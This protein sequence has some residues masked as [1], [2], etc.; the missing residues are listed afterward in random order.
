MALAILESIDADDSTLRFRI[1]TG[2]NTHYQLKVGRDVR[3]DDGDEWVDD[4][5]YTGP[6]QQNDSAGDLFDTAREISLPV[7]VLERGKSFVR[8]VTFKAGGR[9]QAFSDV[10]PLSG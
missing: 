6:L 7:R 8:L 3:E 9:A 1:D 4:V 2:T 10:L 5:Y